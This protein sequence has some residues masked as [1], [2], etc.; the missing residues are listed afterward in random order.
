MCYWEIWEHE[1]HWLVIQILIHNTCI[2]TCGFKW[3]KFYEWKNC[4]NKNCMLSNGHEVYLQQ[5]HWFTDI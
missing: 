3:L 1:N 4:I 5:R 2:Y